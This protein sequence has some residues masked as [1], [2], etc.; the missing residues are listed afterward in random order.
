MRAEDVKLGMKVKIV[1]SPPRSFYGHEQVGKIL[2]IRER[3]GD[4]DFR[5]EEFYDNCRGNYGAVHARYIEP[6]EKEK[7][8]FTKADLKDFMRV[9]Y[10]N[11]DIRLYARGLLFENGSSGARICNFDE[12]LY[13][14][15]TD[16]LTITRV[17]DAPSDDNFLLN[18]NYKGTLLFD[19]EAIEVEAKKNNAREELKASIAK[20]QKMLED[21]QAQLEQLGEEN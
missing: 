21:A 2:T 12:D 5:C 4:G 8:M 18:E 6:V 14:Y 9:Q 1:V 17:W 3:A 19:R 10:Q 20:A 7:K 11:G 13:F 16:I 15:G